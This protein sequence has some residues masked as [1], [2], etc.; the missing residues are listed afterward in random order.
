MLLP[1]EAWHG[2]YGHSRPVGQLLLGETLLYPQLSESRSVYVTRT[3][4]RLSW[5]R[6][7]FGFE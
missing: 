4:W 7:F 3:R 5:W 6:I 1:F 2:R